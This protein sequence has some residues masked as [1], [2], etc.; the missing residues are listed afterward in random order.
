MTSLSTNPELATDDPKKG[1]LWT[2]PGICCPPPVLS[3]GVRSPLDIGR[4]DCDW[5]AAGC[6]KIAAP[7]Y[8]RVEVSWLGAA[9]TMRD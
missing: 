8:L 2:L 4:A 6:E 5:Q 3:S 9:Q 7:Q 1:F